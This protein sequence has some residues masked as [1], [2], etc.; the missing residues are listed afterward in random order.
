MKVL[1]DARGGFSSKKLKYSEW[2]HNEDYFGLKNTRP[3]NM[4]D[5]FHVHEDVIINNLKFISKNKDS[6]KNI[7]LVEWSLGHVEENILKYF[8]YAKEFR[9]MYVDVY[10]DIPKKLIKDKGIK[11]GYMS[12]RS[13]NEMINYCEE[14][15]AVI[16][17]KL[18][19][20]T[21]DK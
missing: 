10:P 21:N 12:K 17:K 3:R 18:E 7:L 1:F 9:G 11:A 6:E 13:M 14:F 2:P 15:I 5:L 4:P 19:E 20:Q 8:K 16:K